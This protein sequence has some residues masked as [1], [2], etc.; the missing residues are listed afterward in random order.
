[1]GLPRPPPL[2]LLSS[3]LLRRWGRSIIQYSGCMADAQGVIQWPQSLHLPHPQ[4]AVC[5]SGSR[6]CPIFGRVCYKQKGGVPKSHQKRASKVQVAFCLYPSFLYTQT[7]ENRPRSGH[8]TLPNTYSTNY[9]HSFTC[10]W[11]LNPHSTVLLE[12]LASDIF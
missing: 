9:S 8:R 12:A 3:S 7:E 2:W 11:I 10:V 6:P 1:V 4:P 5:N